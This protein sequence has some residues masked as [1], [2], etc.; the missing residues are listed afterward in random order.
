MPQDMTTKPLSKQ[1]ANPEWMIVY[2]TNNLSDAHI[3]VGRLE[4][5]NIKAIIDHM[6]GRSAMG[7]TIGSWG[8]VRVLVHPNDY[9]QA[10][11]LLEP[12]TPEEL[13]DTTQE[14]Q[15]IWDEDENDE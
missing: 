12:E 8:E 14:I 11:A 7:L 10:V 6:A 1:P 15:Y 4:S 2:I 3:V 13:A 5:E 9:E